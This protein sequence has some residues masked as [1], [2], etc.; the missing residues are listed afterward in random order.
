MREWFL[1]IVEDLDALELSLPEDKLSKMQYIIFEMYE[2]CR[3]NWK[4]LERLGE[5]GE[6]SLRQTACRV[7]VLV[8]FR[9]LLRKCQVLTSDSTLTRNCVKIFD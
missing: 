4:E 9:T 2:R 7:V 5:G 3:V 1:G 8:S 6:D